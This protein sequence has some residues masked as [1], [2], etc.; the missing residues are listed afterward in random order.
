M[1]DDDPLC[2]VRFLR[3]TNIL[4]GFL[5]TCLVFLLVDHLHPNTTLSVHTRVLNAV[6]V[7]LFPLQFFFQFLYYTD[8]GSTFFV[9][10]AYYC[11]VRR[12]YGL[13]ALVCGFFHPLSPT[14]PSFLRLLGASW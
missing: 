1:D 14:P 7:G 10:L 11:L 6:A 3:I 8:P 4:F 9:L 13:S 2:S 12:A 5:T